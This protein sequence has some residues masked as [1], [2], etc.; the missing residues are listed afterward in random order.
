[1]GLPGELSLPLI[2][3]ARASGSGSFVVR[4]LDASGKETA[5]LA[6]ALG[7]YDGT[8]AV[9][10]I[11]ACANPTVG[12]HVTSTDTWHLDFADAR[13]APRYTSGIAG[14]G[15]SVLTY[16]GKAAAARVDYSGTTPFVVATYGAGGPK[17][18]VRAPGAYRGTVHLPTGPIFIT[19]TAGTAAWSLAPA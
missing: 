5:V 8:F 19:V 4:G 14:K 11:D 10:F 15:D 7:A 12:L 17:V 13:L 16:L 3:H 6:T 2:V 9:G 18:L 1:M